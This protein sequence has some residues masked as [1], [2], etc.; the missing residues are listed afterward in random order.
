VADLAVVIKD[1]VQKIGLEN[2]LPGDVIIANHQAVCGQH[3][4][5]VCV[6]MPF[7]FKGELIGF[8]IIRAHWVDV[9]GMSTA[10]EHEECLDPWMEG[11]ARPA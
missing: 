11:A 1:G 3:L 2:F 8:P 9:G 6:Y 7:F 4:N 10:S 5:N